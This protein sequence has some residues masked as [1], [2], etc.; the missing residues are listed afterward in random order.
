MTQMR[1]T[2][3]TACALFGTA[4]VPPALAAN[5]IVGVNVA[6]AQQMSE[7]QQDALVEQLRQNGVNTVRTGIGE[8][9]NHFIIRA[10]QR[11]I[12]EVVIVYPTQAS[13]N[14]QVRPADR[15]VGL[16]WAEP[17]L[18]GADPEK[19][20][21]WLAAQLTALET[22]KV[23]LTAFEL[24]NEINGPF[25]NGD[26]LPVQ[27][28]GRVLG[29]PDLNNPNDPEGHA[30]AASYRAYLKV[31]AAIKDV[32]DHSAL[33]QRTPIISAGLAD[34][35]LPGKKPGQKLDGV[36][37][38]ATLEFLRQN[39]VDR[40]VDGYGVHVYPTGDPR[41]SVSARSD[42]L[43]KDAFAA[44]TS[45]KPCWLTEWNFNNRDKS[46]PINDATRSQLVQ[47]ERQAFAP[48]IKQG[49]LAAALWYSWSG[50]YAG[51]TENPGAIF[52]CGA[53]TDAGKLALIPM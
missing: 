21:V 52:R 31:M 44:C 8:K 35:G 22:A 5:V 49:R 1:W 46:C 37:I 48:F 42:D 15:S 43:N 50:D 36:S 23:R 2:L 20:K 13:T 47:T 9:F 19:F 16:Q 17:Q 3:L 12:G 51:E 25:F 14:A 32:R 34:G 11:G 29:L 33:N 27:A 39:G 38:P 7:Q 10:Y 6:G 53:L 24:G 45:A 30:I 18:T 28:T 40:L 4:I 41:R 26:F